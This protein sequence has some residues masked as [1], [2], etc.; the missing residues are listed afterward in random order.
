[1]I[2]KIIEIGIFYGME[3]N[4]GKKSN[5]NFKITNSS[6]TYDRPKN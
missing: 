1:M 2:D 4:V 5:E 3:M 6:K